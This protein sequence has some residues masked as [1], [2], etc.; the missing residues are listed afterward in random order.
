[1]G[2]VSASSSPIIGYSDYGLSPSSTYVYT[3]AAIDSEGTASS[4]SNPISVTTQS[5]P[6]QPPVPTAYPVCDQ[7]VKNVPGNYPNIQAAIDAAAIGDT[8][9][10]AAGTYM[11]NVNLKSGICFEGAGVDETIISK[12][13]ASG[14]TGDNI[15]YTVIKNLTVKDSGSNAVDGGG[16]R[17]SGST[18][19]TLQSCRLTENIAANGGGLFA[20]A[21]SITM[22]HCLIDGNTAENIGAGIVTEASSTATLTNDTVAN[23]IWSNSLGNGEVGGVRSYASSLQ[24]ANSILWGNTGQDLSGSDSSVS[25]S[26][27]GGWSGGTNDISHDPSFT[28]TT[29]YHLQS[30]SPATGMGAY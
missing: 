3:V 21:S 24:I 13:G 15:S 19:I 30:S 11:E 27:I 6:L 28:S 2:T 20:S 22:D 23:N 26:D 25:N 1:M 4:Q 18:N 14:I 29:D 7:T 8:V 5:L 9:K 17:L 10:V 12:D 16:I